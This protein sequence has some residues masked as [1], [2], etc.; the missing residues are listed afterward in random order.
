M[1]VCVGLSTM[2]DYIVC[3]DTMVIS[4]EDVCCSVVFDLIVTLI[5]KVLIINICFYITDPLWK[6]GLLN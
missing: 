3:W 2:S 4:G 1:I 6:R 5:M